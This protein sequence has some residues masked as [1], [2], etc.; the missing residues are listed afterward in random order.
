MNYNFACLWNYGTLLPTMREKH[1]L[2]VCKNRVVIFGP[3]RE[4]VTGQWR[5]LHDDLDGLYS[6][7]NTFSDQINKNEVSRARSMYEE[8]D[9]I[10]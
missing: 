10:I 9:N 1:R 7:P 2:R 5:R 4:E 6:S 3:K 8:E